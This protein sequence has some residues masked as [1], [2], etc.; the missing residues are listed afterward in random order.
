V[1]G[2]KMD[3]KEKDLDM[4]PDG[5]R[6]MKIVHEQ[7]DQQDQHIS[8]SDALDDEQRIKVLSPYMLVFR[9]FIRN[10]LAIVGVVIITGMFLFSFV[11]ALLMPY[12][13]TDLFY[14]YDDIPKEYA[15]VTEITEF[16]YEVAPGRDFS[17][18]SRAQFILAT[19]EGKDTFESQGITYNLTSLGT[20]LYLISELE[21]VA[22]AGGSL[23]KPIIT[24]EEDFAGS[25]LFADAFK[26]ALSKELPTFESEGI[27]YTIEKENKFYAAFVASDTA[28]ASMQAFD[29]V[30]V[31]TIVSFAF[32][33]QALLAMNRGDSANFQVDG[34]DFIIELEDDIS[35]IYFVNGEEKTE[36]AAISKWSVQTKA[37]DIFLTMDY[38]N[39]VKQ[40][41]RE[42]QESF[43]YK[44]SAGETKYTIEFELG[45]WIVKNDANSKVTSPYESPSITHW[46]GTDVR[47]RDIVTRMMY[48]GRVSLLIGFVVVIIETLIGVILGGISGY[49]GK[50][51]DNLLMRIVDIFNCIP[52]LPLIIIFGAVMDGM[53]VHSTIRIVYLMIILAVFGWPGIAR[54]VRG[55]I[56][57]LREQEF[58]VAAE[59]TG[60]S[61]YRKIFKHL[62]P[63]VIPQ[64]IV[65]ATMS[66]GDVILIESTLSFL[67]LGV[68]EPFAS[69][70]NIINAVSNVYDMTNYW[71]VWIP[72][73]FCILVT[74]LAFNFIGD[75]LR[76]AFDPK[77]KR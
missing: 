25:E 37:S 39:A 5:Q 13:E 44:G 14:K 66:L 15:Q 52:S 12:S 2:E 17:D 34:M 77:M 58:M 20:D 26:A 19:N 55:Q 76:D 23:K 54:I 21:K 18:S 27:L 56:L 68:K 49:F 28:I 9:R 74:V 16:Q 4:I 57:S 61:V 32:K 36:Y 63:N 10:M 33:Y 46:L 11:G 67:G 65:I 59:A 53:Q 60:L 71:F 35:R 42:N 6:E 69:W 72:A 29:F 24:Y 51:V 22:T 62:V 7:H 41:I 40:A 48:G 75:G 43:I 47:A 30:S 45:Q 8:T 70:G 38:K 50:R 1:K 64:L 3:N 31:D 73:G